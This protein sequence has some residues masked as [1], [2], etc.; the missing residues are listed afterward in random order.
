MVVGE[1]SIHNIMGGM[2]STGGV[3]LHNHKRK[4]KQRYCE[5]VANVNRQGT[6]DSVRF[7]R[8]SNIRVFSNSKFQVHSSLHLHRVHPFHV[9][10]FFLRCNENQYN[11]HFYI[12]QRR[13][14]LSSC[15][16]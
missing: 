8:S 5:P 6:V 4:L 10:S 7:T 9:D 12:Q 3:R 15:S 13:F 11:F 1:A 16:H 14:P 2:E